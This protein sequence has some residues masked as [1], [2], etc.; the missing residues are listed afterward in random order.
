MERTLHSTLCLVKC[1]RDA[2]GSQYD[3]TFES[4]VIHDFKIRKPYDYLQ[5][6]YFKVS[7]KPEYIMIIMIIQIILNLHEGY[8]PEVIA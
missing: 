8:I 3:R 1:K 6:C 4:N 2:F 7:A 5:L